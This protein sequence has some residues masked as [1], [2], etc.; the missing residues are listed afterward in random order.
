MKTHPS[1]V[2][3]IITITG[4]LADGLHGVFEGI[5]PV[6]LFLCLKDLILKGYISLE[7]LNSHINS[8]PHKYTDGVNKPQNIPKS[9]FAK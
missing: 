2:V 4:F 1:S 6:K 7:E 3:L 9:S 5:I 8:F